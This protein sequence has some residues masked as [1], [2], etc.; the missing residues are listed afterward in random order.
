MDDWD[1]VVVPHS[2]IERFALTRETLMD[3][4]QEQ[5]DALEEE[6]YTAAEE[7]MGAQGERLVDLAL[8]GDESAFKNYAR[9]PPRIWCARNQIIAKIEDHAQRASREGRCRSRNGDRQHYR[10]RGAPL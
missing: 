8:D 5:I 3:L 6:A 10:G 9:P 2:L 4:A 1:A 7:D